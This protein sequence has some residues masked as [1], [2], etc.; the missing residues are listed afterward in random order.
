[1]R[2]LVTRPKEDADPLVKILKSKGHEAVT[3]PLLTI[4][5]E[6]DGAKALADLK[7]AD[8][9]AILVTSANG[10][11]HLASADKRRS[12]KILAVGDASAKAAS[13]AGFK[14]VES[15]TGDVEALAKLAKEKCDP[16]KGK[17]IHVAGSR[18]AGDLKGLLEKDGF[19]YVRVVLY[20]ADKTTDLSLTLKKDISAGTINGVLLYS[21]RTATAF[22]ELAEKAKIKSSLKNLSAFCLSKAVA[23][24]LKDAGFKEIITAKT[25]DQDALVACLSAKD[26]VMTTKKEEPVKSAAK[27]EDVKNDTA[28]KK[29]SAASTTD[30]KKADDPVEKALKE[31]PAA[32][33]KKKGSFKAKLLV[34]SVVIVA[35]A[36]VGGHFTKDMWLPQLKAELADRLKVEPSQ[37]VQQYM[38][39]ISKRMA[40]L[41]KLQKEQKPQDVDLTP[42]LDKVAALEAEFSS[43][44]SEISTIE[45]SNVP[46]GEVV[47]LKELAALKEEN[48]RLSQLVTELNNRL[49]D[50]EAARLQARS[51]SDNAQ[52]LIASLSAL[53]EVVRTSSPYG[54]ELKTLAALAQ[55]D[56]SLELAVDSLKAHAGDGIPSQSALISSFDK[57]ANDIVRA[58]AVPEGADWMEQ[59]VKNIT[60][61]VNIRRAPGNLDGEGALG[62]VARAEHNVNNGDL[63]A[64]IKELNTLEGNPLDAAKGWIDQ[65]QA[66][67]DAQAA[68]SKMQ[69]HILSL[70]G[71]TG[72]QG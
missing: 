35:G 12:F 57:T 20:S 18:I 68:L 40:D 42:V 24:K 22:V 33:V 49:A 16:K 27:K 47:G 11:R 53:R 71:G 15:A 69:A 1:M 4:K 62:V 17:L 48:K 25:P 54:P 43:V 10:V 50:V 45:I 3:F 61:L 29:A 39:S 8:I 52:A 14:S 38:A 30:A 7:V 34:A 28:P 23:D 66:R 63:A 6:A 32:P 36:A 19:E 41:E 72:G 64:A 70:L 9:Q 58:V 31:K 46:A 67:L 44:K 59:T 37:E 65:A 13:E 56:V 5:G 21:P 55:G 2:L 51:S 26:E 60:S